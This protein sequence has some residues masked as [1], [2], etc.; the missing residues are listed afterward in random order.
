MAEP[1]MIVPLQFCINASDYLSWAVYEEGTFKLEL[2]NLISAR[3]Y[4]L[5]Y[6]PDDYN[7]HGPAQ[8]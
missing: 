3:C 1:S 5:V 8:L 4:P 7:N 6:V 2:L